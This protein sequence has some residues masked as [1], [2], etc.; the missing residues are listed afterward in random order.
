MSYA[1]SAANI[2]A[3]RLSVADYVR[4][5]ADA[6]TMSEA[7]EYLD[8]CRSR[9]YVLFKAG[10]LQRV[11]EGSR[12]VVV[13]ASAEAYKQ[14]MENRRASAPWPPSRRD[15]RAIVQTLL[16]AGVVTKAD[17]AQHERDR[18]AAAVRRV[19]GGAS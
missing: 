14:Q 9:I 4:N 15:Q 12:Y 6:M 17:I 7:L 16:L 8:I 11:K 10:R 18:L 5:P 13:R 3:G 19:S 1:L 2:L